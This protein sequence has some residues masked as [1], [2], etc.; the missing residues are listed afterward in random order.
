MTRRAL[1]PS[2]PSYLSIPNRSPFPPASQ[3]QLPCT[4][5]SRPACTSTPTRLARKN[6]SPPRSSFLRA[7]ACASMELFILPAPTLY[8]PSTPKRSST[9][10]PASSSF[11]RA[12]WLRPAITSSRPR[13]ATRPA[14]TPPACRP[15]QS[16]RPSM[17]SAGISYYL[18]DILLCG[19]FFHAYR[20]DS[21]V[22]FGHRG[23]G[24]GIVHGSL[25]RLTDGQNRT[26]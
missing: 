19:G 5:A 6:S 24:C 12:S 3:P 23:S 16:P 18:P 7:P 4:S 8:S 14:I 13:S 20:I 25:C 15:K 21:I 2:P 1:L 9:F 22:H 17:S 11:T 10:T 26:G